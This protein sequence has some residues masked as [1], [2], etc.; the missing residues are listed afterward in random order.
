VWEVVVTR[1]GQVTIPAE[2]RRR[3]GIR[4][5]TRLLVEDVGY[6]IL[7]RPVPRLEELAGADRGRYSAAELKR[8]LDEVREE[9][10]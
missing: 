4:R 1:R 3:Y 2:C 7:L 9:W 8:V 10:R 5:G 6:G